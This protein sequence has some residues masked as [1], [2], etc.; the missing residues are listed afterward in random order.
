M[1]SKGALHSG[2]PA[3]GL[4]RSFVDRGPLKA[5]RYKLRPRLP[6]WHTEEVAVVIR[7]RR[8]GLLGFDVRGRS[9]S[10]PIAW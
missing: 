3:E 7:G 5:R 6:F 2:W 1:I 10:L 4:C 8:H 9:S